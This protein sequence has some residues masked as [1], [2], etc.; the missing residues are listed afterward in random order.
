MMKKKNKNGKGILIFKNGK[1][2]E[3]DFLANEKNGYGC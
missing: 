2:Y 1:I 3:G